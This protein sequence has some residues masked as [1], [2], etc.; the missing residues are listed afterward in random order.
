MKQSFLFV[1]PFFMLIHSALA[2]RISGTVTDDKG[3]VLPYACVF[4]KGTSLGTT[5]NNNGKYF[6]NLPDG[7][8][9][10]VCQYVGYGRQEK[11]MSL[12]TE[13]QNLNFQL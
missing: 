6:L 13:P 12:G 11:I 10:I 4:V 7:R 3:N 5:T 2:G 1:F 9:T 8:Y